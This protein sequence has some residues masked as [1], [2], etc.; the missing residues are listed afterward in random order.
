MVVLCDGMKEAEEKILPVL[1]NDP[2]TGVMRHVD[3]G[4]GSAARTARKF[5][6]K[7]PMMKI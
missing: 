1:T 3:A 4:S 7:I 6:I 5:G 2:G